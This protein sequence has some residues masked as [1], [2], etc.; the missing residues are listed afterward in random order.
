MAN[1]QMHQD[2]YGTR[3]DATSWREPPVQMAGG[4][5]ENDETYGLV[6]VLYHALQGAETYMKYIADAEQAGETELVE[7]FRECQEQENRRAL[8]AKQ[9]LAMKLE[10]VEDEAYEADEDE[11]EDED[12]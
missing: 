3:H 11:G 9:L 6:S 10:D 4:S 1:R 2:N 5:A 12:E 7:F 8:R